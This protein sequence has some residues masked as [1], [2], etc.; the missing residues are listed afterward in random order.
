MKRLVNGICFTL[1]LIIGS[2]VDIHAKITTVQIFSL[3]SESEMEL[4]AEFSRLESLGINTVI[5][6]VF[7]N[8]YDTPYKI[9][10]ENDDEGIYFKSQNEPLVS[11][12]LPLIIS[13]AHKHN[14]SVYAWITT[15]KCSWILSEHPE[16]DSL[17]FDVVARDFKPSDQL[18]IFNPAVRKRLQ[19]MLM[20]LAD[21][22]IEGILLQDDL[23]SRQF[24]DFR[25]SLWLSF[26]GQQ[27]NE[28]S[29]YTL[30]SKMNQHSKYLPR[31]YE[32]NFYKSKAICS[33]IG[34]FLGP[35][36]KK[37]PEIKL[38]ANVYYETVTQPGYARLW[39]SQDLEWMISTPL[40]TFAI[41]A[42]QRQMT[43]ELDTSLENV[44]KTLSNA[45]ELLNSSYLMSN[46]SIFWKI[47]IEDW[48]S[49][50]HVNYKELMSSTLAAG[51]FSITIV[52]YRGISS[53]NYIEPIIAANSD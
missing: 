19:T 32:W 9:I 49:G 38:A 25:T 46:N 14:I 52:P 26:D 6:R 43:Y 33:F 5:I 11:N 45:A 27:F 7:K 37:H 36:K 3:E 42:Y 51:N 22:G 10:N 24:D 35:I 28:D 21:T 50:N 18:D 17:R 40:D 8:K 48:S 53:L 1:I 2:F 16:W 31:Y 30:F 15:R 39:L 20:D 41:M 44:L 47:Q 4:E 34:E 23:V 12:L 13:I 29:F